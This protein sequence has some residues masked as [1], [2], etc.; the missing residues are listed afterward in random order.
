MFQSS[1]VSG[2]RIT[3]IDLSL[4]GPA[5]RQLPSLSCDVQPFGRS[6]NLAGRFFT[7]GEQVFTANHVGFAGRRRVRQEEGG[8]QDG[9][10]EMGHGDVERQDA[11]T[12]YRNTWK[13]QACRHSP[14]CGP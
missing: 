6:D 1:P 3:V 11:S 14:G 13:V 12:S 9:V 4:A 10:G 2:L 8:E 5:M 7:R